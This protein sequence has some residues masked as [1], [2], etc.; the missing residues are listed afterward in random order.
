MK[1]AF[2]STIQ[3]GTGN[4]RRLLVALTV[5][6]NFATVAAVPAQ[7]IPWSEDRPLVWSDFQAEVPP[8]TEPDRIALTASSLGWRFAYQLEWSRGDCRYRVTEIDVTASFHPDQSW[9]RHEHRDD[10]VLEHEQGHFD[11]THVHALML[12]EALAEYVG[13]TGE[14]EGRNERAIAANVERELA[15]TLGAIVD[16]IR[17][18]HRRVQ[19]DY[20][21]ETRHS[22]DREAQR[23]WTQHIAAALRGDGR[24]RFVR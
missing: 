24:E 20:D 14:C 3:T 19:E 17:R 18:N 22:I 5:I 4:R 10:H 15:S 8:Q 7:P 1:K 11:I 12:E 2:I 23:Q 16:D 9:A 13:V 6:C 21:R